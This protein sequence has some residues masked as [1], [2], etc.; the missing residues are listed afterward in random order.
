MMRLV[1]WSITALALAVAAHIATL[2][3]APGFTLQRSLASAVDVERNRFTVL[4]PEAQA[5]LLPDY[6]RE[7]VF[8]MCRFDLARGPVTLRANMPD[9]LWV[10]AVYSSNGKTIYTVNDQQSG[11]NFFELKLVRAPSLLDLLSARADDDADAVVDQAWKVSSPDRKGFALLWV[12]MADAAQR[13][14]LTAI[15]AQSSC[16]ST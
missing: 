11:A 13:A 10:V 8:G 16:S 4:T 12:P 9:S 14:Q 5:R 6:P 1:F 3:F 7:S 15:L 2:L